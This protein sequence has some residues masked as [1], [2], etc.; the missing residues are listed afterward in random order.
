MR[1]DYK[2]SLDSGRTARYRKGNVYFK[3]PRSELRIPQ[4]K[5]KR[6]TKGTLLF[7]L[8]MG[9]VSESIG[10]GSGGA[11]GGSPRSTTFFC[12]GAQPPTFE[13]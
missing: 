6:P 8:T 3:L 10:G 9:G 5:K 2:K 4:L 11:G 12:E 7:F 1:K 13:E